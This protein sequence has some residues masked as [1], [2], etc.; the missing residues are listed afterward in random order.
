[1]T[2]EKGNKKALVTGAGG[3]VG[4]YLVRSLKKEG[5]WVRGVD[6]KKP[7]FSNT[8]AD[9]FLQLD[10]R[11]QRNCRKALSPKGTFDE[12]YHLAA[13]RGGM[14]YIVSAE[15]DIMRNNALI[16]AHTISESALIGI[17]KFFY[18][19]SVCV[20]RDMKADEPEL[21]EKDAYPAMPDNEYGWEKLYAE[22]MTQAYAKKFGMD[23]RIA[24]FHTTY[25]PE[26]SWEVMRS[27]APDALCRKA[28]LARDGGELEVWGDGKAIRSFTYIDDI[29][30]GI[31]KLVDSNIDT[32]TNIGSDEYVSIDELA[33]TIIKVSD[34]SL[35]IKHVE[36]EVGVASRNFS[37]KKIYSTGWRSKFSLKQGISILY[38]WMDKQVKKHHS[39]DLAT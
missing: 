15:T 16:D 11:I 10:L 20:Y 9:E 37:K 6:I 21:S 33:K 36:G 25:G 14:G 12:V 28:I 5:Y 19:S 1:M 27:K 18:S 3:F 26:S 29:V 35:K 4:S 24:R 30:D 13:D 23:I 32:P 17:P 38:S 2:R 8:E 22:R 31:R 39:S 7:E 34:K